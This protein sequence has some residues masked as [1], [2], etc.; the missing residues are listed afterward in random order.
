MVYYT[1]SMKSI[2]IKINISNILLPYFLVFIV[3]LL[4]YE[5]IHYFSI[6]I[7]QNGMKLLYFFFFL[8]SFLFVSWYTRFIQLSVRNL[9]AWIFHFLI[10][11]IHLGVNVLQKDEKENVIWKEKKRK[12]VIRNNGLSLLHFLGI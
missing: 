3:S 5:A 8:Q 10:V 11:L 9:K 7:F 1:K 2:Y 12:K 6:S 4:I